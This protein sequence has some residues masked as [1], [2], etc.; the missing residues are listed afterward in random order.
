MSVYFDPSIQ[1]QYLI[2]SN[3]N[4]NLSLS[5]D[6]TIEFFI[7]SNMNT[8]TYQYPIILSGN[9]PSG[10][11]FLSIFAHRVEAPS[12]ICISTNTNGVR[13]GTK[14]VNNNQWHHVA[15]VR[16]GSSTNNT[17]LYV[18]GV[19]DIVQTINFTLNFSSPYNLLIAKNDTLSPENV[20][21]FQGY[22]SNFRIVKGTALYTTTFT[23]PTTSLTNISGTSLLLFNDPF[24][25]F[26]D[27]SS[28]NYTVTLYTSPNVP[29]ASALTPFVIC[30]KEDSK[31]MCF[32]NG[33]EK[34][35][36]V[37][38]IRKGVLVKTLLHGYVPVYMIGT[39]KIW[40]PG[41]FDRCSK[42]LYLLSKDKYP[43]L[44]EDLVITGA[45]S[46]LVDEL[47]DVQ[48]EKTTE[49][50][51]KLYATNNKYRLM[52][53]FDERAVPYEVEGEFN[54]YHFALEHDNYFHNYGV[55]AN[56]L[57]V[58]SCSKRYLQEKSNMRFL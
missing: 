33:E 14:I 28:N 48:I 57:L 39:S 7:K 17:I 52:A 30:F 1:N 12:K 18:D 56:G 54:I 49:K 22:L 9:Q 11:D 46:I 19:T 29:T 40:N 36:L 25:L 32:H 55:Y 31:I 45:H 43:E 15:L 47:S 20:T 8:T 37:Q 38:D 26:A 23:P 16:N 35:M 44:T 41:N 13:V 50:F 51:N 21:K 53:E 58:E 2:V 6:F 42:R 5:G 4:S 10:Q 3:T 27:G 24:N 34:E